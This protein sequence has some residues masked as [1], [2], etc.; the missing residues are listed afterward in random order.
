MGGPLPPGT[1]LAR[2]RGYKMAVRCQ[3]WGKVFDLRAETGLSSVS[4]VVVGNVQDRFE[5]K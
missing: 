2:G 5:T 1:I 3:T 4:D